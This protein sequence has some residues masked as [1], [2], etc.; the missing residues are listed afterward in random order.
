[1]QIQDARSLSIDAQAA[2]RQRVVRAVLSG[3]TQ[4]DAARRFALARPTVNKWVGLY[5][6]GGWT[7]L[8]LG[9]KGRPKGPSRL[10]G[11]QAAQVVRSI[12]DRTP[13]QLKLPFVLWTRQAVA[14]LIEERFGVRVSLMTVGRWLARWGLTP[15][16][17]VRRAWEQNPR[18]VARW[19]QVEYP[20]VRAEAKREGA[21]IHWG[22]ELGLRS[23]HQAGTT[24]GRR[25]VTPVVPGTGQ[26]WRCNM[27]SSISGR[28]T[29]RFMVFKRCF[30]AR[31]FIDFMSRLVRQARCKIYLIVDGHAVH[32]AGE[33]RRWL[34]GRETQI[35]LILLPAYSPDLNPD[36]FLNNDV[37]ANAVGRRR[38]RSREELIADVRGYLRSTQKQPAIVRNYFHAPS[39]QYAM[40]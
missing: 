20:R 6:L 16:K 12:T 39:V 14:V 19:L 10:K 37:K 13:D 9:K 8:S 11:W 15:Q 5:R 22:D 21:E 2:L 31:V 28:G 26:R 33:T 1:M 30:C 23:D 34:A 7:A 40:I 35:R 17:P 36:E 25:G 38:A 29:L 24:Y 3:M 4:A 18:A 32:K 27:I